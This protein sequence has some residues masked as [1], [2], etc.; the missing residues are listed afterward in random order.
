MRISALAAALAAFTASVAAAQ[1][2]S[3]AP[4]FGAVPLASGFPDPFTQ[5]IPAGGGINVGQTV[6]GCVGYIANAP[7]FR[8]D[9]TPGEQGAPLIFS[10]AA[11][12]DTTLV[13]RA[14]DGS[15]LCDDDGGTVSFNPA[16][17]FE[18][19]VA[20]RYDVWVGAYAPGRPQA[21]FLT[22][23]AHLRR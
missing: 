9:F 21:S 11:T 10:V 12:I 14:P 18:K 15:W 3:V 4:S 17:T 5:L 7:D 16:I 23:S 13:I 22:I 2:A 8:I 19:P 1:D 6:P 20:G